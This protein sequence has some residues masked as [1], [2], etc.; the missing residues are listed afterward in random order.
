[1]DRETSM[2]PA[3]LALAFIC[4]AAGSAACAPEPRTESPAGPRFVQPIAC[5]LGVDC[6][7]QTYV[8]AEAG[9]GARDYLCGGETNE[10]HGGIDFR[11]RDM[12]A[13]RA[14]V[15]VLAA[16]DGRVARLRDGVADLSV[17]A[18]GAPSVAGQDCGNGVVLDH[19]GGWETQYCHLA[20]GSIAVKVGDSVKAGQ[21]LARVGLSGQTEFAHLHFEVRRDGVRVD[22]FAPDPY[23]EA[24]KAQPTLWS[25]AAAQA[26][27]YKAGAILNTGF[28]AGP[29]TMAQ[30]EAAAMTAPAGAESPLVAYARAI[31][32]QA[33]D[34]QVLTLRDAAGTVLATNRS[35]ALDRAKA[36]TIMFVGRKAPPGG[37]TRGRY[38]ADY[39]VVRLGKV[40]LQRR[41][42]WS[43][44][45][46]SAP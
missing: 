9:P 32:L 16:A 23:G 27:R 11:L 4:S 15:A 44:N 38:E 43:W 3:C 31:N 25:G 5:R 7:I 1:M 24:C 14:G 12:G 2:R 45:A 8:D 34:V 39:A 35:A 30:V 22:P 46:A 13:Q 41:W 33:G 26:M 36:Q 40:V 28:A 6:E 37:W 19:G 18:P 10:A 17:N 29:V 21:P 20:Q 42:S